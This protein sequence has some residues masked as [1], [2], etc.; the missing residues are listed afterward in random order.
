MRRLGHDDYF[1]ALADEFRWTTME[2]ETLSVHEMETRHI[3]NSMKMIFNHIAH[4]Y[5]G[6]P[7]WFQKFYDAYEERARRDPKKLARQVAMFCWVIQQRGDLPE[8]YI[9][10]Y[11]QIVN[12]ILDI[13]DLKQA[14][15]SLPEPE[16]FVQ[17][18]SGAV[19]AFLGTTFG[20][21]LDS[22]F[23]GENGLDLEY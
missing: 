8:K 4:V 6:K 19:R 16:G 2:G 18:R 20:E 22:H 9:P 21:Y 14:A 17:P 7:V 13:R 15:L 1:G 23:H 5:G 12:Q 10:P 11:I 3:F